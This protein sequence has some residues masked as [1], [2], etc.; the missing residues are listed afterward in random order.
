[1]CPE[2]AAKVR[3]ALVKGHG[4]LMVRTLQSRAEETFANMQNLLEAHYLAKMKRY[5]TE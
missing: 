1:M 4:L 5:G 2:N 3:I